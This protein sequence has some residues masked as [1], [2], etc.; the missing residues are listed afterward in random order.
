MYDT[1]K[2]EIVVRFAVSLIHA[3]SCSRCNNSSS[4]H[5]SHQAVDQVVCA[6]I[7]VNKVRKARDYLA[8]LLKPLRWRWR[9]THKAI[10]MNTSSM[11][12]KTILAIIRSFAM[13]NKVISG[14]DVFGDRYAATYLQPFCLESEP[15]RVQK[16]VR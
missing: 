7:G 6:V 4:D 16:A 11:V 3:A 15:Q 13:V 2:E 10:V 9:I 8:H 5:E 12:A 1:G 14:T